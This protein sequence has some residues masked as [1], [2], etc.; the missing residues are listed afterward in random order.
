ML[1]ECLSDV[2]WRRGF[3]A[4]TASSLE[5]ARR[6]VYAALDAIRIPC[7]QG[8]AVA[9]GGYDRMGYFGA[10]R[11]R[12]VPRSF[13]SPP[14]PLFPLPPLLRLLPPIFPGALE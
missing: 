6:L 3:L 11:E 5:Q 1:A 2:V 10:P 9:T 14:L 13:P 4:A 7:A 12:V 8:R